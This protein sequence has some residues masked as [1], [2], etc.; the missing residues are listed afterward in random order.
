M[1]KYMLRQILC[2]IRDSRFLLSEEVK[3]QGQEEAQQN[4]RGKGKIE[5]KILPFDGNI[6]RQ[7]S[8]PEQSQN[9]R[10]TQQDTEND[11]YDSENYEKPAHGFSL[12]GFRASCKE[13]C[14]QRTIMIG[15]LSS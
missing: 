15:A 11:E 14:A 2:Q 1:G 5:G 4:A 6:T 8:Q 9:I 3:N 7:S 10:K 12:C 13:V